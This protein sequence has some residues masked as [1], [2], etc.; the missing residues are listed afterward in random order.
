MQSCA[1]GLF[2]NY[3]PGDLCGAADASGTCAQKA[4]ICLMVYLPVCGC[5]GKTYSNAC[6]ASGAGVGV[7]NSGPCCT[8]GAFQAAAIG[9]AELASW[10][11]DVTDGKYATTYQ[12]KADGTFVR[13][14]AVSPCPTGAVC[15]WSG[16]VTSAG[17]WAIKGTAV[18]LKWTSA[19]GGNFGLQFPA[20][21]ATAKQCTTWR[22]TETGSAGEAFSKP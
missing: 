7:Y 4:Q 8:D 12:F 9:A 10:W 20:S 21:L 15:L 3:K 19:L 14:D 18:Q 2:C 22:L 13:Q 17:S 11:T 6:S 1:T 16:I 5:N